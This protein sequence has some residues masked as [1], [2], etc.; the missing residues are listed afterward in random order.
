MRFEDSGLNKLGKAFEADCHKEQYGPLQLIEA[1]ETL[2]ISKGWPTKE[3]S[4]N[5]ANGCAMPKPDSTGAGNIGRLKL[6]TSQTLRLRVPKSLN[7]SKRVFCLALR[8]RG[9][10]SRRPLEV[11]SRVS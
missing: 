4:C 6:L 2:Q 7:V 3:A 11:P 8:T 5:E 10:P 1:P 9:C